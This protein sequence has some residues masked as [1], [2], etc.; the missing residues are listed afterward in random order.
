[1]TTDQV[2]YLF[3]PIRFGQK[4]FPR[5]KSAIKSLAL[6]LSG[7]PSW[8]VLPYTNYAGRFAPLWTVPIEA[9]DVCRSQCLAEP[10]CVGIGRMGHTC[11]MYRYNNSASFHNAGTNSNSHVTRPPAGNDIH[12]LILNRCL[13]NITGWCH[14]PLIAHK[15]WMRY[16]SYIQI[17]LAS[18]LLLTF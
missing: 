9:L 8:E 5:R 10:T 14:N 2:F 1:M 17:L 15:R 4:T 16:I 6:F 3:I 7:C 18:Q 13:P 11:M 12:I